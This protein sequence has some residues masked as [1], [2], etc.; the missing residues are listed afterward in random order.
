MVRE[1]E[2]IMLRTGLMLS[3]KRRLPL[4][5]TRLSSS[6]GMHVQEERTGGSRQ[7][8]HA[9]PHIHNRNTHKMMMTNKIPNKSKYDGGP[10]K[11]NLTSTATAAA[12]S[13]CVNNHI[14][15]SANSP[16][17]HVHAT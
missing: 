17:L 13:G 12:T 7:Q 5:R 16:A 2:T 6:P 11:F 9:Y 8:T 10:E 15:H 3:G 1:G 14:H 4:K